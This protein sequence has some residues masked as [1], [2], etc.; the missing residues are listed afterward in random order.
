MAMTLGSYKP[1]RS[2]IKWVGG[3]SR[4]R[5]TIVSLFPEDHTCYVEPFGG[6][7]WVLFAKPPSPVEVYNDIDGELVNFF[8]VLKEKPLE[9]IQSFK[10]ALVSRETFYR[11]A[12]TDPS[13]LSDVQRAHRFFYLIMASWGGESS[14][15]YPR[16]QIAV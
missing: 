15:K 3:K 8:R 16:F 7:A 6:G 12:Q 5:K 4:L 1:L 2:P 10:W 11:L 14:R 9:F 13:G